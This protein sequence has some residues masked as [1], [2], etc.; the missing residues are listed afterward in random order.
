M[1]KEKL[2]K[3]VKN[4]KLVDT[5]RPKHRAEGGE[6]TAGNTEVMKPIPHMNEHGTYRSRK[7]WDDALKTLFDARAQVM[8]VKNKLNNQLLAF[9]R[10]TDSRDA[11]IEEWLEQALVEPEAKLKELDKQITDMVKESSHP[12]IRTALAVKGLDQF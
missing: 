5:H 6:Y 7:K 9:Q 11:G 10:R 1:A 4:P 12:V 8:K 3:G 2:K